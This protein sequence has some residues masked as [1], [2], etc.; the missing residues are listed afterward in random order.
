MSRKI[1]GIPGYKSSN[2]DSFGAGPIHLEFLNRFGDPRII[3]PWEEKVQV[4]LLYLPGGLDTAPSNY[5]RIPGFR[6]SNQDVFKEF[7]LRERLKNYVNDTPVFG[8]CLGMQQIA[9]HFGSTLV[10]DLPFHAQSPTRGSEA[11]S[12]YANFN[13]DEVVKKGKGFKVNSHHHQGVTVRTI[14]DQL[15]PLL[16]SENE[17]DG[18]YDTTGPIVEAFR[19]RELPIYGVQW[20][21]EEWHDGWSVDVITSLLNKEL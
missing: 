14:S 20:H 7:F 18:L 19:H 17:G 15:I 9:V 2:N 5:G 8:I 4:D 12:V 6:T 3:M 21:P 16:V 1:I 13:A 10:Q 11:H